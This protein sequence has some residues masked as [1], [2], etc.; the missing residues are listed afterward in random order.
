MRYNK[1]LNIR[2]SQGLADRLASVSIANDKKVSELVR[3]AIVT[4]VK[5]LEKEKASV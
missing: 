1:V 2:L 5:K 3:E 4:A